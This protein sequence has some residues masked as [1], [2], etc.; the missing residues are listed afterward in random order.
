MNL[1]YENY[2]RRELNFLK[3]DMG[4]DSFDLVVDTEQSIIKRKD[5]KPRTIYV[6]IKYNTSTMQLGAI[7]QPVQIMILSEQ[8]TLDTTRMLFSTFAQSY[9]WQPYDYE[10]SDGNG[11][12]LSGTMK[13]QYSEPVVLSNFNEIEYGYRSVLYIS[14]TLFIAE[15]FADLKSLKIDGE[16][17]TVASFVMT[18]AMTPNTQQTRSNYISTSVK[19]IS[20]LAITFQVPVLQNNFLT[21]VLKIINEKDAAASASDT[22]YGGNENF[23]FDFYIGSTHFGYE[24]HTNNLGVVIVDTPHKYF[25]LTSATFTTLPTGIPGLELGFIK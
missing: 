21:K 25:K 18:Y 3:N 15:N 1:N 8:D 23:E 24:Y 19:N 5:L 20:S 13:Q 7:T 22:L 6:L 16:E 4:L 12:T 11:N 2:L 10:Y 17:I 14:A 9:N